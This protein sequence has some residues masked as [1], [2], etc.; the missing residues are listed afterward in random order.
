[1][2]ILITAAALLV[3]AVEI[4]FAVWPSGSERAPGFFE[5]A[6]AAGTIAAGIW[7]ASAWALALALQL[8]YGAL[9]V[10]AAI[11]AI[12]AIALMIRRYRRRLGPDP[13]PEREPGIELD[14]KTLRIVAIALLPLVFWL[15][16]VM[17]RSVIVPPLSHDALS[18][19]LPKAVLF[20]R[21]EGF[22]YLA[23]LDPRQRNIPAN[24]ELLL[25]EMLIT[26]GSDDYT[27][28]PSVVMFVLFI[29]ACG[30]LVERWWGPNLVR[31]LTV[32]ML[33]AGV[34]VLLLH[35]GAHKND[36]MVALFTVA[37]MV[38]AGRYWRHG[39]T[40]ALLLLITAVALGLGTKPQV[41]GLALFL[42]P[43]V[44][45]RAF[46]TLRPRDWVGVI[47]FGVV[48]FLLLGGAV[49]VANMI[50]ER[51]VIGKPVMAG[52]SSLIAYGD[53][54]NLWEA[55]YV[56]LAAPFS[57]DA[58]V[59]RVPW[60]ERPW[61]WRRYEIFFSHLGIPFALCAL[62]MPFAMWRRR[63][64]EPWIIT[65]T[66]LAA[67]VLMLPVTFQP[68]GMYA[69]SL[70]RYALF[71]VPIV[72]AW[73][74]PRIRYA[75]AALVIASL[76][77]VAY[78]TDMALNDEFVPLDYVLWARQYPG[79]REVAFDPAR[80]ASIADRLAG[81]HDKIAVDVTYASWLYPVFGAKLSR[82]V[83]FIPPGKGPP[84]I[85]DDAQW[86]VIDRGWGIIWGASG[87][88]DLSDFQQ[89]LGGKPSEDDL[90]VRRALLRD[91]RFKLVAVRRGMNQLVFK[92]R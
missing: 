48:A 68:H 32:M 81:P 28:W 71:L 47:A 10:R 79:T 1:M 20:A 70:P 86:V 85:P 3:I 25:T 33:S 54:R 13:Q 63:N 36:I 35:T 42:A 39:E 59:L 77:F 87:F 18:Y 15:E 92:R 14:R 21:A 64:A 76:A 16:F 17:W 84:V 74:V 89:L 61:F 12:V 49:Y 65:L 88:D 4:T 73:T 50:H 8:T 60:E 19:H 9:A 23:E 55:P 57:T 62:A 56:L 24:Y 58:R 5:R 83:Y 66:A 51:S 53:W 44:L 7:F 43:F 11:L 26:Q 29:V 40:P 75:T 72:F 41:A 2:L 82:P 80:A 52:S 31:T 91:P 27:E 90:R 69:I 46:R 6:T 67:L 78:A 45:Y 38:F 22:R 34:P 37:A 30:A